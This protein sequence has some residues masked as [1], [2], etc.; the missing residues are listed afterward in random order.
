MIPGTAQSQ[1]VTGINSVEEITENEVIERT[2]D[3]SKTP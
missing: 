1:R 3:S 2:E